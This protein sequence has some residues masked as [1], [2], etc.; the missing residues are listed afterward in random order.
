M[1]L[2]GDWRERHPQRRSGGRVM[3]YLVLLAVTVLL[4][5]KAGDFSRGFT[6]IFLRESPAGE[7]E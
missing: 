5:L 1:S 7:P 3:F 2:S 6:E 4:I